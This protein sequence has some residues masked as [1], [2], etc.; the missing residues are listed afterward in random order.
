M[1]SVAALALIALPV[2]ASLGACALSPETKRA[3][4]IYDAREKANRT[5]FAS[6]AI[7][8]AMAIHA[9]YEKGD[10]ASNYAQLSSDALSAQYALE[11]VSIDGGVPEAPAVLAWRGV[12][13]EDTGRVT[14]AREEYR[15]SFELKPSF[16]V[17]SKLVPIYGTFHDADSVINTC[18]RT[19]PVLDKVDAQ[20]SFID[21]CKTELVKLVPPDQTLAWLDPQAAAWYQRE[22]DRRQKAALVAQEQRRLQ[23]ERAEKVAAYVQKCSTTCHD[24]GVTC[25]GRCTPGDPAC[26]ER[27]ETAYDTCVDACV[28]AAQK[29]FTPRPAPAPASEAGSTSTKAEGAAGGDRKSGP[30]ARAGSRA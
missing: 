6:D 22:V 23:K 26:Q 14:E 19:Y 17:G 25:Q 28:A 21:L 8:L 9:A 24:R 10:Y 3:Q 4:A 15:K 18:K 2:L 5:F 16:M 12:M 7:E 27:C 30:S 11:R 1:R 29:A 13:Y 20:L